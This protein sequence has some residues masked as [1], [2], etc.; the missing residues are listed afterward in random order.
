VEI[1]IKVHALKVANAMRSMGCNPT[2]EIMAEYESEV[3][4]SI[5]QAIVSAQTHLPA[6]SSLNKPLRDGTFLHV[7]CSRWLIIS[8]LTALHVD[9]GFSRVL[10]VHVKVQEDDRC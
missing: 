9:V 2:D 4:A 5:D 3:R 10:D 8:C 6:K 1:L 7:T